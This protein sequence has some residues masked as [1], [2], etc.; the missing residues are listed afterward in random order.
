MAKRF[1]PEEKSR[2]LKDIRENLGVIFSYDYNPEDKSA[3]K[4]IKA[5]FLKQVQDLAGECSNKKT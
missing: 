1:I 4:R 3:V 2:C 5:D